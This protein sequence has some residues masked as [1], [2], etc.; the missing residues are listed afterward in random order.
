MI[1]PLFLGAFL[2]TTLLSLATAVVAIMSWG[3]EGSL[4]TLIGSVAY[5]AGAFLVTAAGNVPM[6]NALAAVDATRALRSLF[7]ALGAG[8]GD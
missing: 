8:A 1:N 6:N 7:L 5:L 2:G 3:D 4:S